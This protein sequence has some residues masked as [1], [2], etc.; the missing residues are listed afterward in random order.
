MVGVSWRKATGLNQLKKKKEKMHEG[1]GYLWTLLELVALK[2]EREKATLFIIQKACPSDVIAASMPKWSQNLRHSRGQ[3]FLGWWR[4]AHPEHLSLASSML[5]SPFHWIFPFFTSEPPISLKLL[6]TQ[7]GFLGSKHQ[8]F[9]R[10][11]DEGRKGICRCCSYFGVI[12][13]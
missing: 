1:L 5:Y 8:G 7:N 11:G 6:P 13:I 12:Y 2:R 9:Q 4:S 3:I 10:W